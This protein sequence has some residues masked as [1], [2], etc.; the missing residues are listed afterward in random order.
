MDSDSDSDE[1]TDSIGS[2]DGFDY[3]DETE[4][5]AI[6]TNKRYVNLSTILHDQD[7]YINSETSGNNEES[8]TVWDYNFPEMC[9]RL[10]LERY[11]SDAGSDAASEYLNTL[12]VTSEVEADSYMTQVRAKGDYP[13][14]PE[15]PLLIKIELDSE[16]RFSSYQRDLAL[17]LIAE[18]R[19]LFL[20]I[21]PD[22]IE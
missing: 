15:Q 16:G 18:L 22:A 1:S 8:S 14:T 6:V 4:K 19:D 5:L 12:T 10:V 17:S 7:S 21:L 13:Y 9:I 20:E 2:F 3:D 11:E